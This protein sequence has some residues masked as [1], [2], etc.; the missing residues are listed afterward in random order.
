MST[1][2]SLPGLKP[3]RMLKTNLSEIHDYGNRVK[4]AILNFIRKEGNDELAEKLDHFRV[5]PFNY[6]YSSLSEAIKDVSPALI[7]QCRSSQKSRNGVVLSLQRSCGT[8]HQ[9]TVDF[10]MKYLTETYRD[11]DSWCDRKL[12]FSGITDL[13]DLLLTWLELN[14]TWMS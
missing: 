2:A 14:A 11:H 1:T 7:M 5:P 10:L 4:Q 8:N 3:R 12:C 6:R 13:V 9:E